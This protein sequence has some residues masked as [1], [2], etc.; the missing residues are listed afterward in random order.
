MR[1]EQMALA[2]GSIYRICFHKNEQ[3]PL[4]VMLIGLPPNT[5]YPIHCHYLKEELY[6]VYK[7][8]MTLFTYG[9]KESPDD[10]DVQKIHIDSS[11]NCQGYLM[12]SMLW[13]SMT[14]GSYGV[15]FMEIK[16]GPFK[17][18]ENIYPST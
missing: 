15:V 8:D 17:Q 7:G 1:A 18:N 5:S 10:S 4:H 3:Q 6:L 2:S 9:S 16:T 12:H 13:H 14:A 11:G